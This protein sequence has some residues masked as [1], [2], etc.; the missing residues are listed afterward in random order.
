MPFLLC[1]HFLQS[2]KNILAVILHGDEL[3]LS[4]EQRRQLHSSGIDRALHDIVR[5]DNKLPIFGVAF[6]SKFLDY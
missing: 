1:Q 2:R 3:S 6:V 4:M 5:D